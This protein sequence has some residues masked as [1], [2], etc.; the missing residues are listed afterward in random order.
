MVVGRASG[1]QVLMAGAALAA[2]AGGAS[3]QEV[4]TPDVITVTPSGAGGELSG[5]WGDIFPFEGEATPA[6]GDIFPFW[7]DIMPFWGDIMPFWG[8]IFPFEEGSEVA[9]AW[10][11][12]MPFWGD[13]MPFWGDIFP[14]WTPTDRAFT[15]GELALVAA[16]LDEMLLNAEGVFGSAVEARTGL[17]FDEGFAAPLLA[18]Y[19]LTRGDAAGLS[20]LSPEERARFMLDFYDGLMAYSGRDRMDWWMGAANW[21]P[22]VTDVQEWGYA[23]TVGLID[24]PLAEGSEA[25]SSLEW[26]GGRRRTGGGP[27]AGHGTAVASLIAGAHDVRGV[28]GIAPGSD[29]LVFNPF[30]ETGTAN[31]AEVRQGVRRLRNRG[32]HVI[33]LSI[34][35]EGAVLA[36]GWAD[37]LRGVGRRDDVVFV[38]SA[39]NEGL[40]AGD[41]FFQ[42]TADTDALLIVG[43]LS[44]SGEI[45]AFSNRPGQGC[46]VSRRGCAEGDRVM[47]RFLVAPGELILTDDGEGGT[48]RVSGTS[49][50]APLV[51]GTVALLQARWPWLENHASTTA[52][53]VLRSARDLG[54]PGIDAVYGWGAL[55]IEAAQSPLDWDGLFFLAPS[56][57]GFQSAGSL[58]D[59]LLTP[60]LLDGVADDAAVFGFERVGETFRDFAIPLKTR[61]AAGESAEF[62]FRPVQGYLT[63]RMMDWAANGFAAPVSSVYERPGY[64]LSVVQ[65][66]GPMGRHAGS[67]TYLTQDGASLTVGAGEG[68]ATFG[69]RLFDGARDLDPRAGGV[70]SLLGFARGGA[71]AAA[72]VPL[73]EIGRLTLAAAQNDPEASRFGFAED[74][75][76]GRL[77]AEGYEARGASVGLSRAL[78]GAELQVAYQ[79]LGEENG[80]LGSQ[81]LGA[82]SLAGGARTDAVTA[83][84]M[85]PE[86]FGVSLGFSATTGRTRTDDA[87]SLLAL[88]EDGAVSTGFAGRARMEGTFLNGDRTTLTFSQPLG[89]ADGDLLVRQVVVTDRATGARGLS[90]ARHDLAGE[91]PLVM[92]ADYAL[93]V[94][95]GR[96]TLSG[97][98]SVDAT[99]GDALGGLSLGTRF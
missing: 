28:A 58:R 23:P 68:A 7:G 36:E 5:D 48:R 21:T 89:V 53:I 4:L 95:R 6:W 70:P 49:F 33:N 83:E 37:V 69:S 14:F 55:D 16:R 72:S 51:T 18:T 50:A 62:G 26:L 94:L 54:A 9:P 46:F 77:G 96:A 84:L 31:W 90:V 63:E 79:H 97:L 41:V 75:V 52:D 56:A 82:F 42:N 73:G 8:D 25:A 32:A 59:A 60:G 22:A 24:S 43:S 40:E 1:R 29:L 19:G 20:G 74:P 15:D 93:P 12:I 71:Y 91:R 88:G 85:L 57:G 35:T 17:S 87:D 61:Q 44:P 47:D 13:I 81:G 34:G 86:A 99:S 39:G 80:V 38:K 92:E 45:S 11:D 10:G 78:L 66:S 76:N 64:T 27:A 30:D 65:G 98:A 2:L 67:L 3:A